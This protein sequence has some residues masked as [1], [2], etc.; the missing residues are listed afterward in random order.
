MKKHHVN[1]MPSGIMG[2]GDWSQGA[3]HSPRGFMKAAAV[4]GIVL[5]SPLLLPAW[6]N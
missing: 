2:T 1:V 4:S 5:R 3:Q 6:L